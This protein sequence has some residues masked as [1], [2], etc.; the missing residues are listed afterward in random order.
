[1]IFAICLLSLFF[2][3]AL[4]NMGLR[5][6]LMMLQQNSYRASR[7]IGWFKQSNESTSWLRLSSV[8][9]LIFC[10]ANFCPLIAAAAL[11][12]IYSFI[13]TLILARRKYKK[14]LVMTAR[15]KRIMAVSVLL[16]AL[17]VAAVILFI[18]HTAEQRLVYSSITLMACFWISP[19]IMLAA[20]WLLTP[21]EKS[22]TDGYTRDARKILAS[23]PDLRI[24]GITG[25]YGKTSTKHILTRILSQKYETVMTPGSFNTP[26]GV[27]RTIREHLKP[28]TEVFVV[29]M[30]AKN[31]GDIKEI[32]DIVHPQNGLITAVGPQHLESFKTI[33]RVQATKFELVDALPSDGVAV[34]NNDFPKI[35]DRPVENVKAIRYAVTN[36]DG[37][38][39]IATDIKYSPTGTTF[40]IKDTRT[41]S[42]LPLYSPLLGE[43]NVSNIL[44]AAIMAR[45][46]GVEDE[47]ITYAVEHLEQIE[48][49]LSIRRIPGGINILDDAFNSNPVGSAMALDVLSAMN[50]G[51]RILI[52][53]GMIELGT[54]QFD[55]NRD[56]GAKA[57]GCADIVIVV[58]LYNRDAITEGL[59]QAGAPESMI[60][61]ADD[62]N[63]AQAILRTIQAPG[64]TVL[65]ENDLPDTFK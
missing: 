47:H 60:Y 52:T 50:T 41:G 45:C 62:F 27:V 61:L 10:L 57:A 39:Y 22:I 63:H 1:M 21:V 37:A 3:A 7:Y 44:G 42:A 36:A 30:G 16:I 56:F 55:L 15:V 9:V 43:C 4:L 25:S 26:M 53:P 48:H 54:R 17:I 8:A 24:I 18:G 51:K 20:N 19:L 58:G 49:R 31:P 59:R 32:C 65:Y 28:Y 6:D 5:R 33:E 40:V 64:D 2:S 12:I 29:E 11:I 23:M 38:D 34:L 46:M 14:P 35:A 13:V